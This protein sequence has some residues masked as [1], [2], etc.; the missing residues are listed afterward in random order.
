MTRYTFGG[1]GGD[2]VIQ[3]PSAN[4]GVFKAAGSLTSTG[5][6]WSAQTGG[7]Q[8]TDL[9]DPN[10]AFTP[11]TGVSTDSNGRPLAFQGP[12]GVQE[13]W[14]DFGAGRFKILAT[15][16]DDDPRIANAINATGSVTRAALDARYANAAT[17]VAKAQGKNLFDISA[18]TA[19]QFWNGVGDTTITLA[20]YYASA[21]IPVAAGSTYTINNCRNYETF[22]TNGHL[23]GLYVNNPTEA[24]VTFTPAPGVGF[25]GYNVATA[26]A[27]VSQMELGSAVTS[28]E[29]FGV[30]VTKQLVNGAYLASQ[31]SDNA[32]AATSARRAGGVTVYKAGNV[33]LVRS[34]FG[35]GVQ[36]I[37]MPVHLAGQLAAGGETMVMLTDPNVGGNNFVMLAPSS[38]PDSSLWPTV[39]AGIT[40]AIHNP[41]DD[42]CPIN[43]QWSYVGANHGYVGATTVTMTGHGKANA[44][45][46]SQWTDGTRTYTLL[47]VIDANTLLMGH[48]YTVASGVVTGSTTV[49][50]ASLTHVSGA[51]NTATITITGG[52]VLTEIHPVTYG[53]TVTATADGKPL[54]DGTTSAQALTVTEVYTIASFKGLID[55]SRANIG[56]DPFANLASMT[57]LAR[58]SN[59][60]RFTRGQVVVSQT[61]KALE[62]M[63][64]NMGVTQAFPLT[65]SGGWS[66][67]QFMP[68]IGT[69]GGLNFATMADLST[70]TADID[71]TPATYV[72]AINP[73]QRMV[74]WAYDG[75]SVPQY[76]LAMGV[77][78]VGDGDPAQR[79][80]NATTKTWFISNSFKKNY[81]QIAWNKNLQIGQSLSGTGYRAYLAPPDTTTATVVGDGANTWVSLDQIA[82]T[83]DSRVPLPGLLGKRLQPVGKTTATVGDRV[84]GDGLS[85]AIGASPGYGLWQAKDDTGKVE[86]IPGATRTVG[87]Y[88]IAQQG[89]VATL[90]LTGSYQILYLWPIY[91]S[92]ATPVD[93][94]CLEVTA[95]GT[96]FIRHGIYANDPA[97]GGPLVTGPIA[98]FGTVDPTSTG[99]KESTLSG[100]VLPAGWHWYGIVWQTTSTTAPT[101]RVVNTPSGF[102]P[103]DIGSSSALMSG[104]RM[105]YSFSGVTGA[106][107]ALGALTAQQ[108]GPARVAYRRA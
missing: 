18:A 68:G 85:Y 70:M 46:G 36:D 71:I 40:T 59:T 73:A 79:L 15:D 95:T 105:C 31:V 67:K 50:A 63:N 38:T 62:A 7:T 39:A 56:S 14:L 54:V 19:G 5:T 2:Q 72:D 94:A 51:T 20:G 61:V 21:K 107:G 106:L 86:G 34:A 13:G 64:V 25:V 82:T 9:V 27:S 88:F 4:A 35:D 47:S 10:N 104:S 8:Y 83:T 29:P 100:V 58:I 24:P 69:A 30:Y 101:I 81:P 108:L 84:T 98:D 33:L 42:N 28:Y 1:F 66:K 89:I 22:D 87:N 55:W 99:V 23:T 48:Q 92:E 32:A 41:S 91:L 96:G 43:V 44:D 78:P 97:T 17:Y 90:A 75:S 52:V 80:K 11:I 12:N 93:R 6:F 65:I 102:G 103:L 60:Y 74:Q 76:G 77:L 26:K 37:L 45:R 49:P 3:S 16:A 53:R 57:S